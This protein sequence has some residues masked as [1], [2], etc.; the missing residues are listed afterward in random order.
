M[1]M[2]RATLE[3]K[4]DFRLTPQNLFSGIWQGDGRMLLAGT[5]VLVLNRSDEKL[6]PETTSSAKSAGSLRRS[7]V[8]V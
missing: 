6:V 3:D 4:S 2:I 1:N 8:G 7:D 5:A